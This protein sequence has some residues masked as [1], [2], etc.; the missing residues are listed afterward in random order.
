MSS[1]F[2]CF[3]DQ[4]TIAS[5]TDRHTNNAKSDRSKAITSSSSSFPTSSRRLPERRTRPDTTISTVRRVS[6]T[7]RKTATAHNQTRTLTPVFHRGQPSGV[8]LTPDPTTGVQWALPPYH[9]TCA[10]SPCFSGVPCETTIGGAFRCGRCPSG[11]TGDG[12]TCKG[13]EP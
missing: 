7:E 5:G 11:Y 6:P 2:Q 13:R 12:V 8:E 4:A 3:T 9:V 10:D 1:N